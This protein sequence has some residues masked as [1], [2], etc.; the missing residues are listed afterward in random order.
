LGNSS[1]F[2]QGG[3]MTNSDQEV[4]VKRLSESRNELEELIGKVNFHK[5][6]YPGWTI[7]DL[8]AHIAGWDEVVLKTLKA[9]AAGEV[10]TITVKNGI[11]A[12]NLESVKAR[13]DLPYD[14]VFEEFNSSRK[15][16]LETILEMPNEKIKESLISPWGQKQT[17]SD[18]VD[19]FSEHELEHAEDV[20]KWLE[21]PDKTVINEV[22]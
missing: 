2:F 3:E 5:E 19:I 14:V 8:L 17:V 12:F 16:I 4:F 18:L 11:D 10:P 13:K 1:D 9:H 20:H 22:G 7:K 15:M 6:I 21:N